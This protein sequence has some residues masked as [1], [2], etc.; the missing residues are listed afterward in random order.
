MKNRV[1]FYSSVSNIELFETQKFYKTDISILN[2]LDFKV[3]VTNKIWDFLFFWKYDLAFIYFYRYGFFGSVI[4]R[5]YGKPVYF[6]GGIDDLDESYATT[7][8]YKIQKLFFKLCHFFSTKCILVSTSDNENVKKVYKGVLP[9]K[10]SISF[11]SIETE[12]FVCNSSQ[13]KGNDFTSIVW[14]GGVENVKRK[15]VD[16]SLKLFNHL[17]QNYIEYKDSR[18]IVIGKKGKGTNYLI[19]L[20]LELNILDKVVF[21]DEV[22]ESTKIE[23]LKKSRYYMQ[24]SKYEG[25]GLAATEALMARNIIINSGRGGLSDSVGTHGIQVDI[26]E[27]LIAQI[28]SI[29][30]QIQNI[31]SDFLKAG[32]QYVI[33]NF[34]YNLRKSD[35]RKIMISE[36]NTK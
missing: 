16:L 4:A 6:S 7:R 10:I 17:A 1:L 32:E 5:I 23:L 8:R 18:F 33:D 28:G 34:S 25:F 24:L 3:L 36:N 26:N 19:D 31:D 14:M 13:I 11:H 29:H 20:C 22:D 9:H 2:D 35:F 27:N 21:T 15:G 30:K 12:N